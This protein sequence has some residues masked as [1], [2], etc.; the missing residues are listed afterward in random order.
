MCALMGEV[1]S[2][3]KAHPVTVM[4]P[5][6]LSTVTD[7]RA[8]IGFVDVVIGAATA[9]AMLR[10]LPSCAYPALPGQEVA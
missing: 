8:P 7:S 4:V 1:V 6:A 9:A 3:S 10:I 2:A 5:L